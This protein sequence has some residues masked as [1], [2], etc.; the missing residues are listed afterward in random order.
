MF[1]VH[2]HV[3]S[4]TA[5]GTMQEFLFHALTQMN[6][7]WKN[8]KVG[9]FRQHLG[10]KFTALTNSVDHCFSLLNSKNLCFKKRFIE[11]CLLIGHHKHSFKNV[12]KM[13]DKCVIYL[14]KFIV[15][16]MLEDVTTFFSNCCE[17]EITSSCFNK[18]MYQL[19]TWLTN[20][21]KNILVS[22]DI[23]RQCKLLITE[24]VVKWTDIQTKNS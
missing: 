18:N 1:K 16:E 22:I 24:T 15:R 4:L 23:W 6:I 20:N 13:I 7:A 17:K 2:P 11:T 5:H 21:I 14:L 10:Y 9:V 12:S 8:F 3:G 19:R